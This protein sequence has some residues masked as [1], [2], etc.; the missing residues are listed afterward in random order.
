[1]CGRY[2]FK[3]EK[4][5]EVEAWLN[6]L[7]IQ[8]TS[9]LSL[10]VV[11]P[12]QKTIVL[13]KD[14]KPMIARWGHTKWDTKGVVINARSETVQTSP[15]FKEHIKERR[16]VIKA[17][18]FYEWDKEKRKFFVSEAT[19]KPLYMAGIYDEENNFSIITDEV[20]TSFSTLHSRVPLFIPEKYVNQYLENGNAMLS[21]F[22]NLKQL[23]LHWVDQ[24]IQ[25]SLF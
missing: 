7:D 25:T 14:L 12:S 13:K 18:G 2:L 23:E 11:Y 22:R 24:S 4:D 19:D 20:H 1:M 16:C 17:D 9:D 15:F 6:E 10:N 5:D 3:Q 21:D 8:D